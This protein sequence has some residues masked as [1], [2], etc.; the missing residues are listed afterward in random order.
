M[1]QLTDFRV[2]LQNSL[3]TAM[4]IEFRSGMI[5]GPVEDR[6]VGCVWTAGVREWDQDVNLEQVFVMVRIFKQWRQQQGF[7]NTQVSELET[8]VE[9]LQDT[10]KPLQ[11]QFQGMWQFRLQEIE[12]D[13]ETSGLEATL[14]C[15][16]DN[17][18]AKGG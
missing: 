1:G 8:L 12:I 4:G 5:E 16:R 7:A 14:V 10:L 3:S 17:R 18:F 13:L 2:A 15:L 11:A 9:S 6:T